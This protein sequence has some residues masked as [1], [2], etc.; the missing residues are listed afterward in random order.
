MKD[1]IKK[2]GLLII[3][4]F[5]IGMIAMDYYNFLKA[6]D[7]GYSKISGLFKYMPTAAQIL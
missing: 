7:K 3:I 6:K 1:F 2:N 4:S 5:I